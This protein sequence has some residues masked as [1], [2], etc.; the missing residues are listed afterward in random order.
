VSGCEPG[1]I[2]RA[3]SQ[4][5]VCCGPVS[6]TTTLVISTFFNP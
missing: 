1:L 4:L 6:I 3:G 5:K 2:R